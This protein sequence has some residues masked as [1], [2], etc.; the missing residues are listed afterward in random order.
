MMEDHS[1]GQDLPLVSV[2]MPA[3]NAEAY[4]ERAI[5]SVMEQTVDSWEL[6]VL[7][8]CS[9]D[10]TRQIVSALAM[11]DAR[12]RLHTCEKNCGVAQARNRGLELSRGSY[13]AFLDSDDVWNVQKLEKQ[14]TCIQKNDAD[15]CYCSYALINK[16]G[17]KAHADYLVPE[18]VTYEDMLKENF[19]GCS[20][21]MLSSAVAK[22]YRFQEEFY[23]EDYALWVQLLKDGYLASGCTEVL[24]DWRHLENSRSFNKLKSAQKRWEIYRKC[25]KLPVVRCIWLMFGYTITGLRKYK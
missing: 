14:L 20:T 24:V 22:A 1:T 19:L 21:V 10:D 5:R 6:L 23:H 17:Q 9:S 11:Q 25:L 3:Y 4:I 2:I 8:D 7:D 18:T 12:I 15:I 13:V 16:D